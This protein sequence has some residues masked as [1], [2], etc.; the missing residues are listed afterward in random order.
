MCVCV[1]VQK[2]G[3]QIHIDIPISI[4]KMFDLTHPKAGCIACKILFWNLSIM[5]FTAQHWIFSW[6][7]FH[8]CLSGIW[9]ACG[10]RGMAHEFSPSCFVWGFVAKRLCAHSKL[11]MKAW[12]KRF[13]YVVVWRAKG[14]LF[15]I[16]GAFQEMHI[17]INTRSLFNTT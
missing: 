9:Y 1:I 11:L 12:W 5:L 8:P 15:C 2:V 16:M 14:P 7:V 6:P 13:F 10:C 3:M 17:N 4:G